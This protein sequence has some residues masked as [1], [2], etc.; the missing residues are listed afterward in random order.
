MI[1]QKNFPEFFKN[2]VSLEFDWSS[3]FFNLSKCEEEN[4]FFSLKFLVPSIP[5][6]QSNLSSCTFRFLTDSSRTIGFRFLKA[7][8]NYIW[9]F[10]KFFVFLS[11]SS[12][13]PFPQIF[14]LFLVILGQSFKGFL[15]N[16]KVRH[17]FPFFFIILHVFM[18][19]FRDFRI[20][21]NLGFWCSWVFAHASYKHDS[22]ALISKIL[23]LIEIFEIR[24]LMFLRDLG[25]LWNWTKLT[26]VI[27]RLSD[28]N[29]FYACYV[30]QMIN[31]KF[32]FF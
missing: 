30:V 28:Y 16:P 14:F 26:C 15:P 13:D 23:W 2:S 29:M 32:F 21:K 25:I 1:L 17:F 6:D 20:F 3:L 5:F 27:D 4:Q 12:L 31:M 11:D 22:Y 19:L 24:I 8:R 7:Y 10:Q 9:F 18:H